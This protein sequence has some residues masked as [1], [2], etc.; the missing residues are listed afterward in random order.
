MA[1]KHLLDDARTFN[2][3]KPDRY[4]TGLFLLFS[5]LDGI[6]KRGVNGSYVKAAVWFP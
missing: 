5:W 1:P 3:M 6:T 4:R 2:P